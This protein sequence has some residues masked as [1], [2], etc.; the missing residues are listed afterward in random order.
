MACD[1][2]A[3]TL[4]LNWCPG[5]SSGADGSAAAVAG[6]TSSKGKRQALGSSGAAPAGCEQCQ[7]T[8]YEARQ[9]GCYDAEEAAR[10]RLAVPGLSCNVVRELRCDGG[11]YT[12]KLSSKSAERVV[13]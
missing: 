10:W 6:K 2:H 5:S 8:D 9:R 12:A 13:L 1:T 3:L 7:L 4:A 11:M